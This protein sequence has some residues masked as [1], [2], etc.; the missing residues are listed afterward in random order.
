M[1][2]RILAYRKR[3][4]ALLKNMPDGINWSGVLS[5][6]L[7]QIAFFQ[8]ERL[9]HLIV[10]MTV[11]ILTLLSMGIALVT[12]IM[13]MLLLTGVLAVLFIPYI[14]HYYLLENEVQ[15]M[16][17]QYDRMLEL[18]RSGISSRCLNDESV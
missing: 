18:V 9:V 8:H 4:D 17:T 3:I 10:T 12:Q 1:R 6:H 14:L 11:A 5:E 13:T 16:Y 2:K 7:Q 15:K